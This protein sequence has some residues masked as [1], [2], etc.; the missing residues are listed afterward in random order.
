M[1]K[2]TDEQVNR[3]KISGNARAKE[4]FSKCSGFDMKKPIK[5][6]YSSSAAQRYRDMLAK[7]SKSTEAS[8]NSQSPTT[9]STSR[10]IS[11]IDK[12]SEKHIK[13]SPEQS[14][15]RVYYTNDRQISTGSDISSISN[16]PIQ[17]KKQYEG[18]GN[19]PYAPN[20]KNC[21][22]DS[23]PFKQIFSS[24]STGISSIS[25]F[26]SEGTKKAYHNAESIS[27]KLA[28]SISGS[29]PDLIHSESSL[30]MPSDTSLPNGVVTSDNQRDLRSDFS[31]T[32]GYPKGIEERE[33]YT[34]KRSTNYEPQMKQYK[35]PLTGKPSSS[36]QV[37][38]S[39]ATLSLRKKSDED[40]GAWE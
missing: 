37:S 8:S 20:I 9:T 18:F 31:N 10:I 13:N 2:W 5:E 3:M 33:S 26:I 19:Q 36:A 30:R 27:Q 40:W 28:K 15:P 6:K 16:E 23:V 34:Q 32:L 35:T 21:E 14:T 22:D 4:F 12:D 24:I 1:D 25:N 17:G 7:E 39:R 11:P 38:A 29:E